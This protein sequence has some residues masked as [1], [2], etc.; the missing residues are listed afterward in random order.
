MRGRHEREA[1]DEAGAADGGPEEHGETVE[2]EREAEHHPHGGQAH[3]EARG[4]TRA[5]ERELDVALGC[6]MIP[7]GLP[8]VGE[9]AGKRGT[10]QFGE[11]PRAAQGTPARRLLLPEHRADALAGTQAPRDSQLDGLG[12][13]AAGRRRLHAKRGD[14]SSP[15]LTSERASHPS[16]LS[17][18]VSRLGCG[19]ARDVL[20]GGGSRRTAEEQGDQALDD[21]SRLLRLVDGQPRHGRLGSR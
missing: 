4:A 1:A 10:R 18:R 2:A 14:R 12:D 7:E 13:V 8:E 6:R 19:E 17:P 11:R 21:R 3:D 9:T 16:A 15:Q 20:P 5:G